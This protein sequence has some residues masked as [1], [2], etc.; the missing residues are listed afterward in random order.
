MIIPLF[1]QGLNTQ[2]EACRPGYMLVHQLAEKLVKQTKARD[3]SYVSFVLANVDKNW[4]DL[5]DLKELR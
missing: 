3:T 4:K 1:T 2:V 5:Q